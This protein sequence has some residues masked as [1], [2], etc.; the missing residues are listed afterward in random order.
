MATTK[1]RDP[2]IPT[3]ANNWTKQTL[4]SLNVKYERDVDV[5]GPRELVFPLRRDLA[6]G[7]TGHGDVRDLRMPD[8]LQKRRAPFPMSCSW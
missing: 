3:A 6:I 2:L 1:P 8:G 7:E 5:A 4:L